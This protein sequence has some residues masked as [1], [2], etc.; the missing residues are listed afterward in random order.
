VGSLGYTFPFPAV[1]KDRERN[2][3]ISGSF[4]DLTTFVA[5]SAEYQ[6]ELISANQRAVQNILSSIAKQA[7]Q[8]ESKSF[9]DVFDMWLEENEKEYQKLAKTKKFSKLQGQMLAAS[10]DVKQRLSQMVEL[11][12]EDYPVVVRS[13]M[14][15]LY[16]T[17]Y[18][19][20][21]R[22]KELEKQ[23]KASASAKE[24]VA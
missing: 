17:V 3:L 15:D 22:V 2:E 6:Q 10:I 12:L 20:K 16:K 21:K 18:G 11:A 14:D 7:G 9:L 13:E 1:G 24:T 19:L 8:N 4:D 5:K 23:L